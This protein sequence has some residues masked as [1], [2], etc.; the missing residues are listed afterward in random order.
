MP[1]R[2]PN[3]KIASLLGSVFVP[4]TLYSIA[5][6]ALLPVI[7]A[8]AQRLGANIPTAGFIAGLVMLGVLLADL[9]AARFVGWIGERKAMAWASV[10]AFIAV[11]LAFAAQNIWLL[12]IAVT[13]VGASSS[14]FAL[15]RHSFMAEHVPLRFRARAL[16]LLGGTFRAGA[17]IGPLV[18]SGVIA[19]LGIPAVFIMCL[20]VWVAAA[21]SLLFGKNYAPHQSGNAPFKHTLHIAKRERAKLATVGFGAAVIGALRTTRQVGLPLWALMI[22][23]APEKSTLFIGIA[24]LVD[25]ALFYTSGQIMDRFGR[26]WSAVPTLFGLGLTHIFM[27][28][29]TDEPTFLTL[30]ILMSLANGLG[31]GLVLTLGADLAPQDA[32][33]EFLAGYRLLVDAGVAASPP[34][35]AILAASVGLGVGMASFGVLGLG[36]VWVMHRYIPKFIKSPT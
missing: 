36:T 35:L 25:F 12:G 6:F 3:F 30:A 15:G 16:S 20:V 22:G 13:V 19:W 27:F 33:A 9:P 32:R 21:L 4:S 29:A 1:N 26:R 11:G 8:S 5:E 10:S 2:E 17:F 7:P 23:I 14:V 31:S 24:G 34:L 18:G 28:L